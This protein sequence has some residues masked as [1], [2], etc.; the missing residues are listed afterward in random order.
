[1]CFDDLSI[2]CDL[3]SLTDGGSFSKGSRWYLRMFQELEA[4]GRIA[5]NDSLSTIHIFEACVTV[6]TLRT[7][8]ES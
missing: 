2:S 6:I 3:L 7:I 4:D 8:I 5:E 1:M